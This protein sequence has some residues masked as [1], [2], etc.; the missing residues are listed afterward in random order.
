MAKKWWNDHQERE[1]SPRFVTKHMLTKDERENNEGARI[2]RWL[3]LADKLLGN[4]D[5]DN[6][7]PSAA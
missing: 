1:R 6:P 4:T 5:D 2:N 3:E 7:Q